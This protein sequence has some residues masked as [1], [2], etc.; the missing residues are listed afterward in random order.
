M[1]GADWVCVH[2]CVG[3]SFWLFV[4]S[5]ISIVLPLHFSSWFPFFFSLPFAPFRSVLIS[6]F[7]FRLFVGDIPISRSWPIFS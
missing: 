2:A 6:F 1:L 7:S 4:L 3:G 5:F